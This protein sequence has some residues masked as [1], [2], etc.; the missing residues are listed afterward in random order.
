MMCKKVC[1]HKERVLTTIKNTNKNNL[2]FYIFSLQNT[3]SAV[4]IPYY[5][6]IAI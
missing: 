1:S 6:I 3:N 2:H 4:L 5:T